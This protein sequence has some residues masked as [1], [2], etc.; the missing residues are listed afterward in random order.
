MKNR[1]FEGCTRPITE[2]NVLNLRAGAELS[3]T[4][5]IP[6]L[7]SSICGIPLILFTLSRSRGN[8]ACAIDGVMPCGK[9]GYRITS[10]ET[11]ELVIIKYYVAGGASSSWMF[12]FH[13]P[14][15]IKSVPIHLRTN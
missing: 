10:N 13:Y 12:C 11:L 8:I 6:Q 3:H 15:S 5:N 9:A 1:Y 2:Y 4:H 14:Q 7:R